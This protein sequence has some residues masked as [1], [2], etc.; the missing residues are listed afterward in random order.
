MIEDGFLEFVQARGDGPLFYGKSSGDREKKH[1][2]KGVSNRLGTW[3]RENGFNDKRIDPNHGLRHW[4]K[5]HADDVGIQARM[6]D[7]LQGHAPST[8]AAKYYHP[9]LSTKLAALKKIKLP[10]VKAGDDEEPGAK[11]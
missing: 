10:P 3:I 1:A 6:V 4:F 8:E 7:K 9:E 2:S 11:G 5:T